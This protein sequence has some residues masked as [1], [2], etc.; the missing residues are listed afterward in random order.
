M[1]ILEYFEAQDPGHWL[2]AIKSC[3]FEQRPCDWDGAGM[4]KMVRK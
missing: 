2:Q 1:K 4:F 3:G